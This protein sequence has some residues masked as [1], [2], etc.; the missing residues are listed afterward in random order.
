[1]LNSFQTGKYVT[2]NLNTLP[3][4]LPNTLTIQINRATGMDV[5]AVLSGLFFDRADAA[6]CGDP[7]IHADQKLTNGVD[8]TV[9]DNLAPQIVVGQTV[10]GR[11]NACTTRCRAATSSTSP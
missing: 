11:T 7:K 4:M 8:Y 2:W 1:M 9:G 3:D 6:D 10:P 5:N